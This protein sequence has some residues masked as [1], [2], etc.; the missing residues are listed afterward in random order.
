MFLFDKVKYKDILD[1]DKLRIEKYKVTSIVGQSGSGKTTLLR[2]L[3]KL[4]SCDSG[5]IYYDGKALSSLDSVKLRREVVML[6]QEPVVFS[7]SI[8]DNLLAGLRFSEKRSS[9]Q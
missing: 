3:N 7:G 4:I 6:G 5:E 2:L 8:K 9:R 1:I